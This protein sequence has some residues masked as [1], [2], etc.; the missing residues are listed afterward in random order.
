MPAQR[1]AKDVRPGQQV[2]QPRTVKRV[3]WEDSGVELTF[4]DGSVATYGPEDVLPMLLSA[5]DGDG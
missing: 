5:E 2:N 3:V 1:R 4:D